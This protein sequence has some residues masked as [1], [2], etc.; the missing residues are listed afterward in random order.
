MDSRPPAWSHPWAT[1]G[2]SRDGETTVTV[3]SSPMASWEEKCWFQ[4]AVAVAV[5]LCVCVSA[6]VHVCVCVGVHGGEGIN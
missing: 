1:A 5:T 4:I 6:R 2:T 3:E